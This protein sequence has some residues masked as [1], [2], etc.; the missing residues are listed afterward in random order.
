M[1]KSSDTNPFSSK[2]IPYVL[3]LLIG[4]LTFNLNYFINDIANS[5][6]IKYSYDTVATKC[7]NKYQHTVAYKFSNVSYKSK[8]DSIE[9]TFKYTNKTSGFIDS[10]SNFKI[11]TDN[12][13]F[14]DETTDPHISTTGRVASFKI[15]NFQP[16]QTYAITIVYLSNNTK[17]TIPAIVIGTS[18]LMQLTDECFYPWIVQHQF[19][20]NLTIACV[21]IILILFYIFKLIKKP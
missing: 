12:P 5:P 20:L 14:Y 7:E 16:Q 3:G 10:I 6:L 9:L 21:L 1:T 18:S 2:D 11:E 19:G 8:I 15:K 13:S 17:T 4:I